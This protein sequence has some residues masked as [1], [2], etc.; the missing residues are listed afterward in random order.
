MP[1]RPSA[2]PMRPSAMP[3]RP[4]AM[5]LHPD[6]MLMHSPAMPMH[7]SALK[8][9]HFYAKLYSVLDFAAALP[10]LCLQQDIRLFAVNLPKSLSS[11]VFKHALAKTYPN[12]S[13]F[14]AVPSNW[15]VVLNSSY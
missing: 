12:H 10:V 2:M 15:L 8:T 11:L 4:S 7:P 14:L 3:M 6:T 9:L 1:M 5:P 13:G